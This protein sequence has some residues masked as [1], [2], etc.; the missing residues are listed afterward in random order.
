[1]G[2]FKKY[3][4]FL[5]ILFFLVILSG[6]DSFCASASNL[7]PKDFE[8]LEKYENKV[9]KKLTGREFVTPL[10]DRIMLHLKI[11]GG[12]GMIIPVGDSK[13]SVA[14]RETYDMGFMFNIGVYFNFSSM[15]SGFLKHFYISAEVGFM[16]SRAHSINI[17]IQG[18]ETTKEDNPDGTW[19]MIPGFIGVLYEFEIF[20]KFFLSPT[21]SVGMSYHYLDLPSKKVVSG[22]EVTTQAPG[23]AFLMVFKGGANVRYELFKDFSVE[24]NLG[25]MS[26]T[27]GSYYMHLFYFNVWANY[28][29]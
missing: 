29:F 22:S 5:L 6:V 27:G 21:V 28:R 20:D 24:S 26:I 17:I 4:I 10:E 25:W 13:D 11:F 1:M 23:T 12:P 18:S 16:Y 8:D 2:I 15:R 14:F 9:I 3:H 7:E 19:I